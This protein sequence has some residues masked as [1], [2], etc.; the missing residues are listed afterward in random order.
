[1]CFPIEM[2]S[3][4]NLRIYQG[5]GPQNSSRPLTGL[6]G[7]SSESPFFDIN[8]YL[9]PENGEVVYYRIGGNGFPSRGIAP[10]DIV[11]G[12]PGKK[13]RYG[14]LII[15]TRNGSTSIEEFSGP[16]ISPISRFQKIEAT[17]FGSFRKI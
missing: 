17:V 4:M 10:G 12:E 1:M 3:P 15:V 7:I 5:G 11:F 13:P 14:D 6:P 16:D 9:L 2:E 8:E